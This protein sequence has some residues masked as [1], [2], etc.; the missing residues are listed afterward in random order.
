M[1]TGIK[2]FVVLAFVFLV[3]PVLRA[4][5]AQ[6]PAKLGTLKAKSASIGTSNLVSKGASS[7][8]RPIDVESGLVGESTQT[9]TDEGGVEFRMTLSTYKDSSGAYEAYSVLRAPHETDS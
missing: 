6:W 8:V 3:T 2:F 5:D 1:R 7:E 9:Y 4:A